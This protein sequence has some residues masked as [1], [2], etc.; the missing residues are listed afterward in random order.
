MLKVEQVDRESTEYFCNIIR[1]QTK[2]RKNQTKK[3]NDMIDL[4][5]E[6][7]MGHAS[8]DE[9]VKRQ[10]EEELEVAK[11]TKASAIREDMLET[12][13]IANLFLLFLAGFET[14]S[15]MMTACIFFLA[16]NQDVQERLFNE[17]NDADFNEKMD[18]N[19]LMSLQYLDMVVYETMR[20][21]PIVEI[22]RTCTRDYAVPGTGFTVPKGMIVQVSAPGVMMDERYYPNP[23]EFN[24]ENFSTANK[25]RRSPYAFLI[26]GHGPRNCI[27]NRLGLLQFKT[28]IAHMVMN[29]KILATANTPQ[30][31]EMDPTRIDN[32][33]KGGSWVRF[34]RRGLQSR[35][36]SRQG[37]AMA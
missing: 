19:T 29:F 27:G 7:L 21:F 5:T 16:R 20:H 8:N 30:K 9:E 1:E 17:I 15:S 18:Y 23:T 2:L 11:P 25:E 14:S 37:S 33:V 24:P 35:R 26:F 4:L 6:A 31:L 36:L 28:G 10:V 34:E 13:L 3:R 12:V 32:D 22:E